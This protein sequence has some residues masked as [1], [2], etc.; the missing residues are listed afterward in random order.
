LS[1]VLY[2]ARHKVSRPGMHMRHQFS[3]RSRRCYP[4][5]RLVG[6]E[7][8]WRH[9]L[10]RV[11]ERTAFQHTVTVMFYTVASA[12]QRA[13]V[14]LRRVRRD[15]AV[16]AVGERRG[17]RGAAGW[18][19]RAAPW[20]GDARSQDGSVPTE[21]YK[22][23]DTRGISR[24]SARRNRD[25]NTFHVVSAAG[26]IVIAAIRDCI[27]FM[28]WDGRSSRIRAVFI[29]VWRVWRRKMRRKITEEGE[30]SAR[31]STAEQC[32]LTEEFQR[33]Q[34]NMA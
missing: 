8:C 23:M 7:A 31:Q 34:R 11:Q 29:Q 28:H 2:Q 15:D 19:S 13:R 1:R 14:H 16:R 24:K 22:A 18:N 4:V 25:G 26:R 5:A 33:I 20:R 10:T 12:L 3:F 9:T 17:G 6:R 27:A 30:H 32:S 21:R